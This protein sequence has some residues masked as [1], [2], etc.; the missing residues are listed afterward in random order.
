MITDS[1]VGTDLNA[2]AM[3]YSKGNA[4]YNNSN[5]YGL[6]VSKGSSLAFDGSEVYGAILNYSS[7]FSLGG[8]TDIIGS[9]VSK[10]SVDFQSN[11][12]SIT[13]GNIPE[14][15]GLSIGL[16]PFVVPGSYLEY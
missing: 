8:D 2:P 14:F 7:S 6:I 10:Y 5:M 3:C 13:K 4:S 9:V 16:D 12:V 11:L 1:Q 15:A